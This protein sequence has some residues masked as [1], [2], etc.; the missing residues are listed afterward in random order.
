MFGFTV[1]SASGRVAAGSEFKSLVF[2]SKSEV[3]LPSFQYNGSYSGFTR[4]DDPVSPAGSIVFYQT[5]RGSPIFNLGGGVGVVRK[6]PSYYGRVEDVTITRF[7]FCPPFS[8]GD[9]GI[10]VYDEQGVLTFSS[11]TQSMRVAGVFSSMAEKVYTGGRSYYPEDLTIQTEFTGNI[12]ICPANL[13]VYLRSNQYV[14]PQRGY[15]F[16]D[17]SRYIR[18]LSLNSNGLMFIKS[19][20]TSITRYSGGQG[21]YNA[22]PNNNTPNTAILVNVEGL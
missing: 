10:S 16:T 1:E 12:A 15:Y 22:S 20:R 18:A 13:R 6:Q 8:E 4:V 21:N 3:Y 17:V 2:H 11:A 9:M 7:V 14:D 5:T 19:V